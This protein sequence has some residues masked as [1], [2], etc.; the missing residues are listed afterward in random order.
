MK[1]FICLIT[2]CLLVSCRTV[3]NTS[4]THLPSWMRGQFMDDY[5]IRY[6]VNDTLFSMHPSANYH[7][8]D[9]NEKE[10]YLLVKN[11][12]NNPTE[13]GLYS[14][15]DYLKFTG[16]EPYTCG[17]CLTVYNAPDAA[18]AR[19]APQANRGE[20]KKGCNGFPFSRMKKFV[21]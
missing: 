12:D 18:S 3:R 7:I 9:W 6:T 2:T 1:I 17:F 14:R 15:I 4:S 8:L 19:K 11:G 20:P 13:K 16:M 5:N 10:Q 21:Q